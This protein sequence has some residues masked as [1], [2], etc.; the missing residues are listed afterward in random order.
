MDKTIVLVGPT[1]VGKTELSL[2]LAE[3]LGISIINADSRQIYRDLPIGTAAP[4]LA[5]QA[6]VKH[7]LVG[8]HAIGESYNAG[9]FARDAE[10]ILSRER[11][12]VSGG[13]M[14]YV[15]ALLYGIDEMP[16]VLDETRREVRT[17][18]ETYGLEWLRE[19]V[20]QIDP[21]YWST[22]DQSNPQRLLRCVEI[23]RATGKPYSTFRTQEESRLREGF[24]LIG[25]ERDRDEL[26]DRINRRV[27]MMIEAGL[28]AE[29]RAVYG[30]LETPT[31]GYA[32]L[33]R[34]FDGAITRD[35][36]IALI[37]Q[38]SRHYA[39]RQ[40][41]WWRQNKDITWIDANEEY[42]NQISHIL[43][44]TDYAN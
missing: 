20:R 40:L 23:Y 2:R 34:Y 14:L 27:D 10:T 15:S 22:V 26:Y 38:N 24:V 32:E 29:A 36:A 28:E 8:T 4:S 42:E 31:V 37:K 11:A 44:L 25:L 30:R 33:F 41:T 21:T 13:A 7:Y 17:D 16:Q 39:K 35:E 19:Q 3:R 6:R 12:L 43:A 1:G 9:Q 18:Y 5:E